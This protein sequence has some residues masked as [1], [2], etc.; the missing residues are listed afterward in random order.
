MTST[1]QK[2]FGK[3]ALAVK[4]KEKLSKLTFTVSCISTFICFYIES[5]D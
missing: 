2:N 5:L 4:V 3:K 1:K